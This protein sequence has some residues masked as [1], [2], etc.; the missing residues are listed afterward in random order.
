M[1]KAAIFFFFFF[2][3]TKAVFNARPSELRR[4]ERS[5][6]QSG[7]GSLSNQSLECVISKQIVYALI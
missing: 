7:Q 3:F 4:P 1:Y 2:F 6:V 5:C